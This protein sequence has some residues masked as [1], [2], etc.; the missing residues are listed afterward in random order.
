MIENF[1]DSMLATIQKIVLE[2]CGQQTV[3]IT[4]NQARRANL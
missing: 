4:Q 3:S 2:N 1:N